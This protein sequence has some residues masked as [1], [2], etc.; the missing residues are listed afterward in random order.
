VI[1][2]LATFC[3]V[4][5]SWIAQQPRSARLFGDAPSAVVAR[6][7]CR[8]ITSSNSSVKANYKLFIDITYLSM[9]LRHGCFIH[10]SVQIERIARRGGS[11]AKKAVR[12]MV[13]TLLSN[14]LMKQFNWNGWCGKMAFSKLHCREIVQRKYTS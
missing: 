12:K 13:S 6:K 5:C 8:G 14:D 9:T 4:S 11:T 10:A 2:E 1:I 7:C 3:N